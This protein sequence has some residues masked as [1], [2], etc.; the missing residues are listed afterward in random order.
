MRIQVKREYDGEYESHLCFSTRGEYDCKA[1]VMALL[2][3]TPYSLGTLG[4]GYVHST[5]LSTHS[6]VPHGSWEQALT[7]NIWSFWG[8]FNLTSH[9]VAMY[10]PEGT[11]LCQQNILSRTV[12]NIASAW[13]IVRLFSIQVPTN[14]DIIKSAFS[15]SPSSLSLSLS[16]SNV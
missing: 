8:G 14:T 10:L 15:A 3:S 13:N 5:T 16:L 12:P 4:P 7:I 6:S 2:R 1:L 9:F 11:Q